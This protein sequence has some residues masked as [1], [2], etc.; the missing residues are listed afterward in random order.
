MPLLKK[1]IIQVILR[2]T[3][4][5]VTVSCTTLPPASRPLFEDATRLIRLEVTSRSSD[6]KHS[7]PTLIRREQIEDNLRT[8]T[9][10]PLT[11]SET[12]QFAYTKGH[13]LAKSSP[14]FSPDTV[15]FLSHYLVQGL[16]RAT[17]L[18]E[19]VFFFTNRQPNGVT[20]ITDG[21]CYWDNGQLHFL[22]ANYRHPTV[23]RH[24]VMLARADPLK[25]LTTSAYDLVPGI[26][27]K[28]DSIEGVGGNFSQACLSISSLNI[29]IM[30][31]NLQRHKKE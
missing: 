27:G 18:E 26:H 13:R 23:G 5:L 24:E 9:V 22:V 3:V 10:E 2:V 28:K 21:S 29:L 31:A 4:L 15:R 17:S 30:T 14:A 20:L 1:T 25:V 8:I 16:E 12:H 7:H 6:H 19:I 11:S